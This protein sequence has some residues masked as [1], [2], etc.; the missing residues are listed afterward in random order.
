MVRGSQMNDN[1]DTGIIIS[2]SQKEIPKK[3]I[4]LTF[5]ADT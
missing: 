4:P 1:I 3:I 2:H 5:S